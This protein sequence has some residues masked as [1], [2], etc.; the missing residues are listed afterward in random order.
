MREFSFEDLA[1]KYSEK[2]DE[3][4]KQKLHSD[5]LTNELQKKLFEIEH[6]LKKLSLAEKKTKSTARWINKRKS[7]GSKSGKIHSG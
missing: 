6:T 3:L 4:E 1:K 2:I 7:I 5:K